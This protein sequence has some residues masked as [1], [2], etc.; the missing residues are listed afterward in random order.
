MKSFSSSFARV[1]ALTQRWIFCFRTKL[2]RNKSV[3]VVTLG[4]VLPVA[5]ALWE[6]VIVAVRASRRLSRLF[7]PAFFFQSP[8]FKPAV[9]QPLL[10]LAT[11]SVTKPA[12][13]FCF[14]TAECHRFVS[15]HTSIAVREFCLEA[16]GQGR[17]VEKC[18]VWC[19]TTPLN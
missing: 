11:L 9:L 1:T 19:W 3:P 2:P 8:I 7:T 18:C 12:L 14:L 6:L 4:Q 15:I 5:P 16:M 10:F 17:F 13:L